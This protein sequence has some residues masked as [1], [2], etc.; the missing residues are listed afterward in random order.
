MTAWSAV[1]VRPVAPQKRLSFP[2]D[3]VPRQSAEFRG[4]LAATTLALDLAGAETDLPELA[5]ELGVPLISSSRSR[6][7]EH[8][9]PALT[10]KAPDTAAACELGRWMLSDHAANDKVCR[11][12]RKRCQPGLRRG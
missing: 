8:L 4:Y 6:E 1:Y 2:L 9:W 3:V 5:A 7:Q 11:F 10:L 12:A